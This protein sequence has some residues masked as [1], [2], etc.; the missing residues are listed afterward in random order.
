M[1]DFMAPFVDPSQVRV[2][3]I[4]GGRPLLAQKPTHKFLQGLHDAG[5]T[6]IEY[7][8]RAD[9]AEGYETG[10]YRINTYSGEFA[11]A[12]AKRHWRHPVKQWEAGGFHGAF[13]GREWA[14]QCAERD[15]KK[16]VLQLD[17]NV[18]Y[19]G[20]ICAN[21][22]VSLDSSDPVEC[23]NILIGLV[24]ST[25]VHMG[26]M[27]LSAVVPKDEY[28]TIRPGYPYSVFVE[29]VAPNRPPYWGPF[30][31]DIMHA[32][33]YAR[34]ANPARTSAV[35]DLLTYAKESTSNTGMRK[36]YDGTRGLG[37]VQHYPENARLTVTRRTSSPNDKSRGVRHLLNTRRFNRVRVI[38]VDMY[39]E[40]SAALADL[41]RR[42]DAGY[43]AAAKQKIAQR[44]AGRDKA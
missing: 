19:I 37:L 4:S 6:D 35:V 11:D 42:E 24:A 8:V 25:S 34:G 23:F 41:V 22:R 2:C 38:D 3:V 15:G 13:T 12:W 18:K 32:L 31:D 5:Y 10:D 39:E 28:R 44:A 27:Q 30:E 7:V 20:P 9:Q 26:G 29:K 40:V 43:R 14:M 36:H 33:D 21:R 17:D 16:Y 1:F